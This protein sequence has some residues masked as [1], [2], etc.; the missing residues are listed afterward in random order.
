MQAF[1]FF[2]LPAELR[3]RIYRMHLVTGKVY[4]WSKGHRQQ[5]ALVLPLL[6]TN[7]QIRTEALSI[8]YAENDF[9][10]W[11]DIA[12]F[13]P[14]FVRFIAFFRASPYPPSLKRIILL[15]PRPYYSGRCALC[16][17]TDVRFAIDIDSTSIIAM[18]GAR[19]CRSGK[20]VDSAMHLLPEVMQW[21]AANGGVLKTSRIVHDTLARRLKNVF[22]DAFK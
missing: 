13:V 16:R 10:F 22:Q 15:Y 19:C 18:E 4:P 3:N 1:R 21:C 6:A 11:V 9:S 12:D 8:Y 5:E 20:H 2:D 14:S 7:Q 17:A